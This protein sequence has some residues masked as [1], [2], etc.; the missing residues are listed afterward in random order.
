MD[1]MLRRGTVEPG[2]LPM[3]AGIDAALRALHD[4]E[5]VAALSGEA[6]AEEDP[7]GK[8]IRLRVRAGDTVVAVVL[9]PLAALRTAGEILEMCGRRLGEDLTNLRR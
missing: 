1:R 9:S 7:D 6:T 3:L 2:H 8:S 5:T 4:E